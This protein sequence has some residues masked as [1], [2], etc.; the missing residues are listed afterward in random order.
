VPVMSWEA[1]RMGIG[2]CH[3]TVKRT[4]IRRP[5]VLTRLSVG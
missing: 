3:I 1:V 4:Y 5:L 2:R